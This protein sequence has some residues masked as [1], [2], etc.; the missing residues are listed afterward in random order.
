MSEFPISSTSPSSTHRVSSIATAVRDNLAA[1]GQALEL[2]AGL[3]GASYTRRVPACFNSS[4]GGHMRHVIEHY[5]SFLGG[6]VGGRVDYEARP[7]DPRIESEPGY[8]ADR[9]V[10]LSAEL[11]CLG[12]A[13]VDGMLLR[14]RSET[15][16]AESVPGDPWADSSVLRELEY[17]LS[18]TVHHYALIGVICG[19]EGRTV[20]KDF[21]MA[22]S[23]LR[24]LRARA[25]RSAPTGEVAA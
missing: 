10:A 7:R 21:G 24:Y 17:L 12:E 8:A 4:A 14:V 13:A 11:G 5:A 20:P 15:A 16:G 3:D 1:L 6:L 22:P 2:L 23:T 19:M 25:E 18:H 9:I